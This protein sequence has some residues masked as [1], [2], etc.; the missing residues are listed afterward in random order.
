MTMQGKVV[1]TINSDQREMEG[2]MGKQVERRFASMTTKF[3]EIINDQQS[4][5][6]ASLQKQK[7]AAE[8]VP[9]CATEMKK[10]VQEL[11]EIV[12]KKEDAENREVNILIH[13]IP[14]STATDA[15]GRKRYDAASFQNMVQ[16]LLGEGIVMEVQKIFRLG[17]RREG[18]AGPNQGPGDARQGTTEEPK[19]RLMLAKLKSKEDVSQMMNKRWELRNVGFDNIYLTRD[20]SPAEREAQR[21]L[22][23]ELAQKGKETHKIFRGKVVPYQ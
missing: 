17:K 23:E 8:S 4:K 6:E 12:A 1:E 9:G 13:N 21:K 10:N 2:K 18:A 14:E 5:V 22:R 11:R 19:P 15:E 20:L 7:E 3:E 16:A